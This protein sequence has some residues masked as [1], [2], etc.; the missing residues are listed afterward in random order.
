MQS[1]ETFGKPRR[2]A[3]LLL[4][5]ESF[6][7]SDEKGEK[8]LAPS[9]F[10]SIATVGILV[11]LLVISEQIHR[12]FIDTYASDIHPVLHDE[13][14]RHILARHIGVDALS[15]LLVSYFGFKNRHILGE[16]MTFRRDM[17]GCHRRIYTYQPA[18]HQVLLYFF[19]FQVKNMYDTIVWNDGM[20]YV[21]HHL[22]AGSTA[23]LGMYPGV[24]SMY[25]LFFMGLSEVSTGILCLLANF[26]PD[27][28]VVGLDEVFP[29]T[30][31]VLGTMFVVSFIIVRIMIWPLLTYHFLGDVNAILKRNS[32]RETKSVKLTLYMMKTSSVTLTILQV[33]WL[34][35]VIMTAKE[36]ISKLL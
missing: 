22:F 30:R 19:A 32:E 3:T 2:N 33:I 17:D 36:E 10:A 16:L 31:L 21:L 35:Q 11:I 23:W 18:G 1:S 25:G 12:I 4:S 7:C 9:K 13:T 5:S 29:I 15:C 14:N 24:A 27:A 20:L 28:G 6:Q 34:G 8:I 26:D